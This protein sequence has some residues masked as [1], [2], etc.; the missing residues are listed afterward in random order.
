MLDKGDI[1][2]T[3]YVSKD[4]LVTFVVVELE[5]LFLEFICSNC[6]ISRGRKL[7]VGSRCSLKPDEE[8]HSWYMEGQ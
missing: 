7:T 5:L 8:I 4:V 2:V 1:M 6:G 3:N